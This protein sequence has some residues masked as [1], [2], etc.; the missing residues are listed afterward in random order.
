[1]NISPFACPSCLKTQDF[2]AVCEE[3]EKTALGR[4]KNGEIF[5]A[6]LGPLQLTNCENDALAK[7]ESEQCDHRATCANSVLVMQRKN[8]D[9]R[10]VTNPGNSALLPALW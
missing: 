3:L 10:R 1:M 2:L 9:G 4:S 8:S 5:D 6:I 7:S